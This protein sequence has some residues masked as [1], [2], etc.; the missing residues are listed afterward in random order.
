MPS[1]ISKLSSPV[2]LGLDPGYDRVGWAIAT[3]NSVHDIS[4]LDFGCITTDRKQTR[5]F[6]YNQIF[7]QLTELVSEHQIAELAIEELFFAKNT[8][9]AMH[10][11]EA[12]G[13]MLTVAFQHNLAIS[14]YS[15]PQI[16][17]AVTG[18]GR[19]SKTALTKMVKL[20]LRLDEKKVPDDSYDALGLLITHAVLKN[21]AQVKT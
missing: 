17:L 19:A 14:E 9:T 12:R 5:S 16:K 3:I 13:V 2:V 10:V 1:K 15:P 21:S 6:R 11:A 18:D 7:T 8:T 4:V 20:Q